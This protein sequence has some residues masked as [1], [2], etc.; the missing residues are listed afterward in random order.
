MNSR[1]YILDTDKVEIKCSAIQ[2]VVAGQRKLNVCEKILCYFSLRKYFK[3][4][5]NIYQ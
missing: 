3:C 4:N 2:F 5:K 1:I